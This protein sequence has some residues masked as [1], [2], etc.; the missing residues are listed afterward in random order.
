MRTRLKLLFVIVCFSACFITGCE[1]D[2]D[3]MGAPIE[4]PE[5]NP[6]SGETIDGATIEMSESDNSSTTDADEEGA[7]I[8]I[9][10]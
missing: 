10:E 5:L 2:E 3:Q 1:D 4:I 6:N 8:E 9:P 7:P